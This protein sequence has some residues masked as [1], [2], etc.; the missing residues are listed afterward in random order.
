MGEQQQQIRWLSLIAAGC[1]RHQHRR[2]QRPLPT[3]TGI[4]T[5]PNYA[6]T[7]EEDGCQMI[8]IGMAETVEG[9]E[10]NWQMRGKCCIEEGIWA[11]EWKKGKNSCPNSCAYVCLCL[12]KINKS[13]ACIF[14]IISFGHN[15]FLLYEQIRMINHSNCSAIYYPK[16]ERCPTRFHSRVFAHAETLRSQKLVN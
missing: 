4:Q 7:E 9:E 1:R 6:M 8:R 10:R 16:K 11:T 13:T 14:V 15:Y 5:L 2:R 3:K 12:G